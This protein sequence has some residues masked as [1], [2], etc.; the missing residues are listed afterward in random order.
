MINIFSTKSLWGFVCLSVYLSVCLS[1]PK[2]SHIRPICHY[3]IACDRSSSSIQ[4]SATGRTLITRICA[5]SSEPPPPSS[6]L[7][8]SQLIQAA[9]T[10]WPECDLH[11]AVSKQVTS[12]W[13]FMLLAPLIFVPASHTPVVKVRLVVWRSDLIR[14]GGDRWDFLDLMV[15]AR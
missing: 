10:I 6:S 2:V 4:L 9:Q 15:V 12:Q 5:M 14:Q 1:R 8:N 7:A 11:A 3:I 13:I